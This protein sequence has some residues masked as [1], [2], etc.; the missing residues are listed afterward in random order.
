MNRLLLLIVMLCVVA[1]GYSKSIIDLRGQARYPKPPIE[2]YIDNRIL[3]FDIPSDI[4]IVN[5]LIEDNFGNIVFHSLLEGN[6]GIIPVELE[7]NKGS[8]FIL[9]DYW[10]QRA[11]GEFFIQ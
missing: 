10:G 5:I 6:K 8:Y 11:R 4:G 9:I 3:E 7:L 1:S 2:V